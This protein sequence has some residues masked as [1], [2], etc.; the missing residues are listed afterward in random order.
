[1]LPLSRRFLRVSAYLLTGAI[2]LAIFFMLCGYRMLVGDDPPPGHVEA[3]VVLQ[4]SIIGEKA[5]LAG[6]MDLLRRGAVDRVLLSVPKE[7]YWGQAIPPVAHVYI[8]RNYGADLVSRVDFCELGDDVD[9]TKQEMQ[10]LRPCIEDHHWRSVVVVTSDYHT[11][12]AGMIWR[13][14]AKQDPNVQIWM[15]GVPDPEF[16]QPWWKYRRSAK[17]F[18]ME[19]TKLVWAVLGG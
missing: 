19:S 11:R 5:R 2:V 17:V 15:D 4:G 3:A 7:S 10:A 16:Q 6:A 18:V 12:R 9:S 14:L 13:K 8:E 1:M